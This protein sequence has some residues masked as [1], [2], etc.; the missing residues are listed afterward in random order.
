MLEGLCVLPKPAAP[1]IQ[2]NQQTDH[3][4]SR[5][6]HT[7][8]PTPDEENAKIDTMY[9]YLP[10]KNII[11]KPCVYKGKELWDNIPTV[12]MRSLGS[13]EVNH[14]MSVSIETDKC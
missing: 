7:T 8:L 14:A 9:S 10:T 2:E 11:S 13:M 12:S 1:I 4:P 3:C 6:T 5:Y